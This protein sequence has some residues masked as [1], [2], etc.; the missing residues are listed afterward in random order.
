MKDLLSI[1]SE[2]VIVY[3]MGKVGSSSIEK[4]LHERGVHVIHMHKISNSDVFFYDPSIVGATKKIRIKVMQIFVSAII[5]MKK[6]KVIT[7]VRDP[8]DRTISQMFH[9]IDILIYAHTKKDS[10]AEL[11]PYQLFSE[12][13]HSDIMIDYTNK[14]ME[15]EF[16]RSMCVDFSEGEFDKELGYGRLLGKKKD[17]LVVRFESIQGLEKVIGDFVGLSCFYL[18]KANRGSHKWYADLYKNFYSEFKVDSFIFELMYNN[19]YCDKYYSSSD[20]VDRRNRWLSK[21]LDSSSASQEA[22]SN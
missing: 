1:N 18:S 3:Q 13:F 15:K 11:T 19:S 2:S 22:S 7:I 9:H 10:R 12:I 8:M 21:P 5:G 6:C 4:A 20:I 16:N 14:W 17:I